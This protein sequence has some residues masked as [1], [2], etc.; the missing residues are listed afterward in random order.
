MANRNYSLLRV[1]AFVLAAGILPASLAGGT[2]ARDDKKKVSI[3]ELI[4]HHVAA[5]G[6]PE[7]IAKAKARLVTGLVKVVN[8][9]GRGGSTEGQGLIVSLAP[10]VR[11]TMRFESLD[12]P[13]EQMAY[14]G[15]K[16]A[17]DMLP[18][19]KRTNLALFLTQDNLPLKE[20]LLCGVLSTAWPFLRYAE[21]QPKLDYRGL[22]KVEGRQLHEVR[23]RPRKGGTE[24]MVL[25]YFDPETYRHVRTTYKLEVSGRIGI[26]P[27]DSS[28]MVEGYSLL[29]EDFDDFRTVDGLTLPFTYK[30][31]LQKSTAQD[32]S[33]NDW[34]I[35]VDKIEHRDSLEDS[36]FKLVA[37]LQSNVWGD[38]SIAAK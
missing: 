8:R 27:A 36:V 16:S 14:D 26:N 24:L 19:G 10:K 23:Y 34:T 22:K 25:L 21:Q 20:G 1:G 2:L 37:A 13:A 15:D 4:S 30:L 18:N 5:I 29:S 35:Q 33:I 32:S 38:S 12:Y 31:Q 6:S 9:T 3:D 17:V 11:Y 7:A 28:T